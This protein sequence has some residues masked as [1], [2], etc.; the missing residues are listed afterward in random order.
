MEKECQAFPLPFQNVFLMNILLPSYE[1]TIS[2]LSDRPLSVQ[3]L[4]IQPLFFVPP[5]L[6]KQLLHAFTISSHLQAPFQPLQTS[7]HVNQFPVLNSLCA[8]NCGSF[9]FPAGSWM[10]TLQILNQPKEIIK[11]VDRDFCSRIFIPALFIITKTQIKCLCLSE[12]QSKES[13]VCGQ[14]E[15]YVAIPRRTTTKCYVHDSLLMLDQWKN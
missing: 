6:E 4:T 12:Y 8:N 3:F 5:D 13:M 14:M 1:Q 9:C 10:I 11:C 15:Y 7:Q 2:A